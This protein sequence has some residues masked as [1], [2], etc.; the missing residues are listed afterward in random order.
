MRYWIEYLYL[1]ELFVYNFRVNMASEH[2][3][4]APSLEFSNNSDSDCYIID[5]ESDD[6]YVSDQGYIS[7]YE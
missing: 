2:Q 5:N 7:G 3:H 6:D 1:P 4:A